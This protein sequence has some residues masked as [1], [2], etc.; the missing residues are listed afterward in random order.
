[1]VQTLARLGVP[2][3]LGDGS[4]DLDELAGRTGTD[5][6][7]LARLLRAATGLDLVRR[8]PEGAYALTAGGQLPRTGR[9]GSIGNLAQLFCGDAVWRAWRSS[10]NAARSSP[11]TSSCG[12]RPR[13]PTS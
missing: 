4:L 6:D 12:C 8:T 10:I 1:M 7:A 2:D 11:A 13:T 9:P 5:P 3:A